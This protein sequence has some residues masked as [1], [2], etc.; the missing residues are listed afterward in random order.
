MAKGFWDNKNLT[1]DTLLIIATAGV[2][3][4]IA[5]ISPV[6]F[7][8]L[9]RTY[10][11]DKSR[12]AVY[13]RARKI[14]ELQRKKLISFKELG[15]GRVEIKLAHKGKILVREYDLENL[16]FKKPKKWDGRWHVYSY[17]IPS[18][19]KKASDA[20]RYKIKQIGLFKI[21]KSVWV[22]PYDC[23]S[24]IEFL[25]SVFEIDINSNIFH[26]ITKEIPREQEARKFFG[27]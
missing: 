12:K 3:T 1:K 5:V 17:D 20:F 14:R 27:V 19:K 24:E 23:M 15:D 10:F 13:A 6:A 18:S 7:V 9:A 11:H 21:Q 25:T 8:N 4:M 2:I 26:I 16:K 22:F